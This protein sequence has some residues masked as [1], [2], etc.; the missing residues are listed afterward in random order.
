MAHGDIKV[1]LVVGVVGLGFSHVPGDAAASEHYARKG[2]VEGV[3]G[4]DDADALCTALPDPVVGQEF[5]GF[6]DTVAELGRPL[7]DVVEEAEGEV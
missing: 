2:I 5:F 7:V 4:G 1:D 3:G 6:V